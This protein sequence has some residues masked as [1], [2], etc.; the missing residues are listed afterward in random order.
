MLQRNGI[1]RSRDSFID[2]RPGNRF[3]RVTIRSSGDR[4]LGFATPIFLG[5]EFPLIHGNNKVQGEKKRRLGG[6]AAKAKIDSSEM[7]HLS[8]CLALCS[9][10]SRVYTTN[11]LFQVISRRGRLLHP[12]PGRQKATGYTAP[13]RFRAFS[14]YTSLFA[15][16][17]SISP[18]P[19]QQSS[20]GP[21]PFHLVNCDTTSASPR[22]LNRLPNCP[23]INRF[24][25][26]FRSPFYLASEILLSIL[27]EIICQIGA[28]THFHQFQFANFSSRPI[29]SDDNTSSQQSISILFPEESRSWE[30]GRDLDTIGTV[31]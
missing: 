13:R 29:K 25:H 17:G 9:I 6:Q 16:T 10:I 18:R 28:H 8:L 2:D 22:I 3:A 23:V 14:P 31:Y 4:R 5:R 26:T 27:F 24:L 7:K 15:Y 1:R 11:G 12:P 30:E 20:L 21:I 19:F